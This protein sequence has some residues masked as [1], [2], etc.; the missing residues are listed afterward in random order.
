M[1][2]QVEHRSTHNLGIADICPLLLHSDVAN[3]EVPC[4]QSINQPRCLGTR[5]TKN[6]AGR[7]T[8]RA[9]KNR[10]CFLSPGC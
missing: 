6:S 7:A 1:L 9:P 3:R 2:F 10:R 8:P 4:L 5:V